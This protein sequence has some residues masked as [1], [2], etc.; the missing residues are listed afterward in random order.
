VP[1]RD[2]QPGVIWRQ[3]AVV[4]PLAWLTTN[5]AFQPAMLRKCASLHRAAGPFLG[6]ERFPARRRFSNAPC[7]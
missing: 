3:L 7:P 5:A 1:A 6:R 2:D 4:P